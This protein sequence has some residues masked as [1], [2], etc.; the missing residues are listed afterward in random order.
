MASSMKYGDGKMNDRSLV[1]EIRSVM[2]PA[3]PFPAPAADHDLRLEPDLAA[4]IESLRA[5]PVGYAEPKGSRSGRERPNPSRTRAVIWRVAAPALSGLA[6]AVVVVSLALA[7]GSTAKPAGTRPAGSSGAGPL[8]RF[9]VTINGIPPHAE[10]VVHYSRTGR[11]VR[12]VRIPGVAGEFATVAAA[13]SDREFFIVAYG[14]TAYSGPVSALY[15]LAVADNGRRL[16][17]ATVSS[18]LGLQAGD[19]VDS[20]ALSPDGQNLAVA[21]QIPRRGFQ[22]QAELVVI[23]LHSHALARIWTTKEEAFAWDPVWTSKTDVVFLWQ[24][25]LEG[26]VFD[27]TGRTQVRLL[28]TAAGGHDLLSTR[29]LATASRKLGFIASAFA[30]PRGGPIIASAYRNVPTLG[31]HGTATVRLVAISPVTG[32]VIKVF[33][34]HVLHYHTV[35]LRDDADYYYQVFGLDR[36]GRRALVDSPGF[37]MLSGGKLAPLPTGRG[38]VLGAAW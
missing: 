31:A 4:R 3:N 36:S 14:P 32:K 12:Y 18:D 27:Y 2:A 16:S 37:G 1:S 11:I 7:G 8:P 22:P 21:V 5:D 13:R 33:A 15:R 29:V 20:I 26:T 38:E 24:D 10:A 25:H 28:N 30:A 17:L 9:Y 23:P 35:T 19:V 6:V 34:T